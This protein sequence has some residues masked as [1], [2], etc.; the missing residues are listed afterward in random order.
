ME[1]LGNLMNRRPYSWDKGD[2]E[3]LRTIKR[4]GRIRQ[5]EKFL[6]T[7]DL[8][9]VSINPKYFQ[10][11]RIGKKEE[12]LATFNPSHHPIK[13]QLP[14]YYQEVL[15]LYQLNESNNEELS[16][17]GALILKRTK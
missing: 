5:Q 15:P 8:E 3:I 14:N 9:I 1:G 12:L 2:L 13:I 6:E 16:S 10:F 7:A 4:I 17:H 11:K